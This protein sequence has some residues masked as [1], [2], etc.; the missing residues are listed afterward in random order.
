[1][2]INKRLYALVGVFLLA[3]FQI[4]NGFNMGSRGLTDGDMSKRAVGE[5]DAGND[6]QIKEPESN[7]KTHSP[8]LLKVLSNKEYL[9]GEDDDSS[10]EVKDTSVE[11]KTLLAEPV[12]LED[13]GEEESEFH[14]KREQRTHP[15]PS[16]KD[17]DL[18]SLINELYRLK[19]MKELMENRKE[20]TSE[21]NDPYI[22]Y[23]LLLENKLNSENEMSAKEVKGPAEESEQSDQEEFGHFL[24]YLDENGL[25]NKLEEFL[26]AQEE[27]EAEMAS[28][29]DENDD[30]GR[31]NEVKF[32]KPIVHFKETFISGDTY[33]KKLLDQDEVQ[34]RA[35]SFIA[36][37]VSLLAIGSVGCWILDM[38]LGP[39]PHQKPNF[40]RYLQFNSIHCAI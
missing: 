15:S 13:E 8:K 11:Q 28:S 27:P 32:Q 26:E 9:F 38:D 30:H 25:G 37:V 10:G 33:N 16:M 3:V 6:V 12:E 36:V 5:K 29:G 24:E 35:H 18:E 39:D 7:L 4:S 21:E 20:F 19:E 17:D 34:S 14:L 22:D 2:L 1:M 31:E 40:V 23:D